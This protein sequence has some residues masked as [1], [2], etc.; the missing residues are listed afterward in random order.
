[1]IF[2]FPLR[3]CR[4]LFFIDAEHLYTRPHPSLRRTVPTS[5][6]PSLGP[7]FTL[8]HNSHIQNFFLYEI[9]FHY[10][11]IAAC[12]LILFSISMSK[13]S[14]RRMGNEI[15]TDRPTNRQTNMR[16]RR[17]VSLPIICKSVYTTEY[18]AYTA[19]F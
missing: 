5:L 11:Q 13:C 4:S 8:H 16:A 12:L 2:L 7:Y 15:F 1:M 9:Y 17:K 19:F 6:T 10:I 14:D 18:V 3:C